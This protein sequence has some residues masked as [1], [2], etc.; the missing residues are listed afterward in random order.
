MATAYASDQNKDVHGRAFKT[1][2]LSDEQ[3]FYKT[4]KDFIGAKEF[5]FKRR[6]YIY[7]EE[8]REVVFVRHED[9]D[10]FMRI[11]PDWVKC[12]TKLNKFGEKEEESGGMENFRDHT[13][14]QKIP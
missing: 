2:G 12:I 5:K 8:K 6:R 14:L 1:L 7:N 13:R 3:E 4:Y 10:K 11:G 9:A